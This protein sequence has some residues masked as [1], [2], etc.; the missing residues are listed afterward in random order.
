MAAEL[1][2]IDYEKNQETGFYS[3]FS[4][5]SPVAFS[6]GGLT[7]LTCRELKGNQVYGNIWH[8]VGPQKVLMESESTV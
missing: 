7:C 6:K 4:L 1:R 3:T 5:N 2:E 8:R